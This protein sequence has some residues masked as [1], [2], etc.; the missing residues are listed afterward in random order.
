[1]GGYGSGFQGQA[2]ATTRERHTL[3]LAYF[4]NLPPGA[5][6]S[7]RLTRGG[8]TQGAVHIRVMETGALALAFTPERG[9]PWQQT[10]LIARVPVTFGGER[11]WLVCPH[12][13]GHAATLY[14]GRHGFTCRTCSGVTYP[15]TRETHG[16]RAV[17][18]ADKIRRRLGWVPGVAHGHGL[19]P[20]GMH[21]QTFWRLV[22][23]HDQNAGRFYAGAQTKIE[24][25]QGRLSAGR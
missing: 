20:K 10:I 7:W 6:V 18:K 11:P 2:K 21:W 17:R 13:W 9:E 22:Q 12:C 25:M 15:S 19:K 23:E 5:A 8:R 4:K 1:M 14:L 16:D 24:R 3:P